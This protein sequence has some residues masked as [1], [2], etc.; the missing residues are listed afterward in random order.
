MK[1]VALVTGGSR[2]IGR[3]IVKALVEDGYF[4]CFTFLRNE[5]KARELERE[6]KE[7]RV[8]GY[9]CDVKNYEQVKEVVEKEIL[10]T[11]GR[12]DVLVN[13]A[14]ITK[15]GLFS[16]MNISDFREVIEVNLMGVVNVTS[17]CV[18]KMISERK[19]VIVNIASVSGLLGPFGQSNYSASKAGIISFTRSLAREVGRYGIRVVAVAPGF[20]ETEMVAKV[21]IERKRQMLSNISLGRF[22]KPEEIASVV[23]FLVS[24]KAS[25]ITG[26]TIVVDG[27]MV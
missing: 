9:L 20:V 16:M 5:E 1:G 13:N 8:K 26:C 17:V 27:G 6:L 7:N 15:D 19:G 22:A 4:V 12:I 25:Y 11:L 2:G 21:P 3:E 10:G 14:G 24:E 23:S 18:R